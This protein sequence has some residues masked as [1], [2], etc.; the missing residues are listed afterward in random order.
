MYCVDMFNLLPTCA[1][2]SHFQTFCILCI[3]LKFYLH[4][5]HLCRILTSLT[6]NDLFIL[7]ICL[8]FW[9]FV[10]NVDI[11]NLLTTCAWFSHFQTFSILCI[12]LKFYLHFSHLC[13]LWIS[14]TVKQ[15]F[16]LLIFLTFWL[17][18]YIFNICI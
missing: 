4:F 10:L 13:I 16:I 12:M 17:F 3:K 7:L 5:N 6:V 9:P 14:L 15:F 8:S 2:C 18:G 11:L 1:R